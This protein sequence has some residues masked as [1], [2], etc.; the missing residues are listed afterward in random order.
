MIY[1]FSFFLVPSYIYTELTLV[2]LWWVRSEKKT[3]LY[4]F[5]KKSQNLLVRPVIPICGGNVALGLRLNV[6]DIYTYGG[7]RDILRF[8]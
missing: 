7:M 3:D 5:I 8:V 2:I 1:Y 6:A 4:N